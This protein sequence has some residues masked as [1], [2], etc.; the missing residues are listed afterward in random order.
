M[1]KSRAPIIGIVL[2]L[3]LAG[4]TALW[5]I[6]TRARALA[7]V[8]RETDELAIPTVAV[9][10]PTR[11]AP[12]EEIS[13]P[14]TIQPFKEAP[15]YARTNGYLTHWTADIGAHVRA[16]QVLAEIDTP[17]VDQQ[18][19]Q[20]RA[21][22]ATAE[23]NV[24]LAESTAVRYRDLIKTESVSQQDLDAA[25]GGFEAKKAAVD[26]ARFNVK[27]LED[28]QAFNRIEAPFAGVITARNVDDGALIGSGGKELFHLASI[29]K[30]RVFVSVPQIYS[31]AAR[32][33]LTADLTLKEFPG[34]TFTGMLARTSQSIDAASR[35][36]LIEVD[37]GN[38]KG[39]LLPG[40]Y[41]EVHLHLPTRTTTVTLPTT[42]LIFKA[43]GLQV[44]TVDAAGRVAIVPVTAGR[45]FG[46]T[47]EVVAG[48]DGTERVIASPSD[49]LVT[50]ET[51]RVAKTDE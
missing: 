24:K 37:V 30:L 16:G 18:L 31:Q 49:S 8:T 1:G 44:A 9:I 13:L 2:I 27:R 3:A 51:I 48:L 28:L 15:I 19:Q 32:P 45:D 38:P 4:G 46:S 47:M 34:R 11:G 26:S 25:N 36:L 22:L 7:A 20:A 6:S 10:T 43:E 5:G 23:A 21:D 29:D 14:G 40:S 35:S 33:G 42:A 17:E 39:E 50:G 12:Q 41:A